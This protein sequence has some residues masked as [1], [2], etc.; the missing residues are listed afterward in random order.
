MAETEGDD[1]LAVISLFFY[2]EDGDQ[3]KDQRHGAHAQEGDVDAPHGCL[4]GRERGGST[5]AYRVHDAHEDSGSDGPGDGPQGGQKGCAVGDL[6][7]LDSAV[8]PGNQR[9]QKAPDGEIAHY[10]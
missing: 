7:C 5:L 4:P 8:A 10:V 6:L 2:A 3:H 1:G 9:H